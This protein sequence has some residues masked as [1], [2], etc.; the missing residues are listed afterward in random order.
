MRTKAVQ[1]DSKLFAEYSH[2]MQSVFWTSNGYPKSMLIY[3]PRLWKIVV[4]DVFSLNHRCKKQ[5]HRCNHPNPLSYVPAV[6]Y[7][8]AGILSRGISPS[9]RRIYT[10]SHGHQLSKGNILHW[11]TSNI[12]QVHHET[13]SKKL[14]PSSKQ[15]EALNS[16]YVMRTWNSDSNSKSSVS[17]S[18]NPRHTNSFLTST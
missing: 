12:K 4:N 8:R 3:T 15:T 16:D 17:E 5:G 11:T 13:G 7:Q 14:N 6:M 1:W 18:F 2:C 9:S 10:Q